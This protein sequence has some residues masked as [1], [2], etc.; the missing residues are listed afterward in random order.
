[1]EQM[2]HDAI[3]LKKILNSE[4]FLGKYPIIDRVAVD[5]YGRGIDIVLFPN[6]SKKYWE[7]KKEIYPYIWDIAKMASVNVKSG[8]NIYP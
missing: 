8:F 1:M 7:I 6:D 2:E 3:V 4:L 5:L